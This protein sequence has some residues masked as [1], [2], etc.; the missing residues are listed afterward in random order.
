MNR[1]ASWAATLFSSAL[2]LTACVGDDT[3]VPPD[4]DLGRF[5][6]PAA[7]HAHF[8]QRTPGL[9]TIDA[10][11]GRFLMEL[12]EAPRHFEDDAALREHLVHEMGAVASDDG[13]LELRT[14][15]RGEVHWWDETERAL[16]RV[17]DPVA[18]T[19]GGIYGAAT[20]GDQTVCFDSDG[21]CQ[22]LASYLEPAM[23]PSAPTHVRNCSGAY[24]VEHHSFYN[25]VFGFWFRSGGNSRITSGDPD[26]TLTIAECTPGAT[27]DPSALI[28]TLL[29]DVR[30]GGDN[31]E[32]RS[33]A[34]MVVFLRSGARFARSLNAGAEFPN[35]SLRTGSFPLR[36]M[37]GR[38]VR[39]D[40]IDRIGLAT[41]FGGGVD[42]DNWNVDQL[43]VRFTGSG[44]SGTLAAHAGAPFVR[45]TGETRSWTSPSLSVRPSA[46]APVT[47]LI[48]TARTGGD[49][50]RGGNDNVHARAVVSGRT[51]VEVMLN[52][53]AKWSDHTSHTAVVPVPTGTNFGNLRGLNLRTTFGGGWNGDNW[54]LDELLVEAESGGRRFVV[55]HQS[56]NPLRRFTASAQTFGV[57]FPAPGGPRL[58]A[59]RRPA[60][61][62]AVHLTLLA[63]REGFVPGTRDV[64][65]QDFGEVRATGE[66]FVEH[67][68]FSL[69]GGNVGAPEGAIN[70]AIGVCSGH[71]GPT[72]A[73]TTGNGDQRGFCGP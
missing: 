14:E 42:G 32:G 46:T 47:R 15:Q 63:T 20:V 24:C 13:S 52:G 7:M 6:V 44:V 70:T 67:A 25:N 2:G 22:G 39:L 12:D 40:E 29:F 11:E 71:R 41:N 65:P 35:N 5:A 36:S 43:A 4:L 9:L 56:R 58:C 33:N 23:T 28:D 1:Y 55:F 10:G 38:S 61:E 45:L 54:N 17:T 59:T 49:D 64:L 72:G 34:D 19:L 57:T 69:F 62:L 26:G 27:L 31:L 51:S 3:A 50:L 21:E 73:A 37:V 8:G 66:D 53:G 48:V 60:V 68:V 18:A 30:T 16:Y